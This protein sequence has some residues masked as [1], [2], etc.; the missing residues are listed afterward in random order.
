MATKD[1]CRFCAEDNALD[2]LCSDCI[3]KAA[4]YDDL[5]GR[6][7]TIMRALRQDANSIHVSGPCEPGTARGVVEAVEHYLGAIITLYLAPE[8]AEEEARLAETI[9]FQRQAEQ[10]AIP[11][12]DT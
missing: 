7:R 1:N 10:A 6:L 4:G 12:R 5:K 8:L 3:D 11:M 2:T 9:E